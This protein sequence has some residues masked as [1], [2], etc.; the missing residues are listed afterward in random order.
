M[1]GFLNLKPGQDLGIF[2]I[3]WVEYYIYLVPPP[4]PAVCVSASSWTAGWP[5]HVERLHTHCEAPVLVPQKNTLCARGVMP[6]AILL[7]ALVAQVGVDTTGGIFIPRFDQEARFHDEVARSRWST[8]QLDYIDGASS[9][10]LRHPYTIVHAPDGELFVASFT[11]NHVVKLRFIRIIRL[12]NG[13]GIQDFPNGVL[14]DPGDI[15]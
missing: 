14:W 12:Q 13:Y 10:V 11:L 2:L 4:R 8:S 1:R 9:A 15:S 6:G 7:T 3:A 5:L